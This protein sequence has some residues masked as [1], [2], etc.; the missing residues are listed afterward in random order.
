[1]NPDAPPLLPG[2]A[3]FLAN[4]GKWQHAFKIFTYLLF[5]IPMA[6]V[7]TTGLRL[8]WEVNRLNTRG[9]TGMLGAWVV[10]LLA[11]AAIWSGSYPR[12]QQFWDNYPAMADARDRVE[13][14]SALAATTSPL[15]DE[16]SKALLNTLTT[17][18]KRRRAEEDV[19]LG[20]YYGGPRALIDTDEERLKV[21][22]ASNRRILAA[23]TTYL[24]DQQLAVVQDTMD[25]YNARAL[26]AL[27]ARRERLERPAN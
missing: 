7:I 23:A 6:L 13:R 12:L 1:V 17:E 3:E 14:Y 25:Q 8:F 2:A 21:R 15:S 5:A 18:Y 24:D 9:L 19:L 16:Q 4:F 11:S 26:A 27:Q 20:Y 10:A 22:E